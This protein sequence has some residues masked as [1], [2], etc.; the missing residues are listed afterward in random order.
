[1]FEHVQTPIR[2]A[3]FTVLFMLAAC[4]T[5]AAPGLTTGPATKPA[6]A[7][8]LSP[9]QQ[10]I[11]FSLGEPTPQA[12]GPDLRLWAT[13]YHTPIIKPAPETISAAFPLLGRDG[14]PISPPLQHHD[15]CEAAL[16]GSVSIKQ[17]STSTAYVFV[18]A[19]GPEQVNC[20]A[21][22]GNLSDGVKNATRRARF[23]AVNHP[24]G[25]GVRNL[26]LMPF[27]T[28]AVDPDVI[29]LES[30]IFVPE[31]RGRTFRYDG[32]NFV[33][34]GYLFAGDRGGAIQ[35]RH[36]D[37]FMVDDGFAPLEDLFASTDTR[38][39]E[40]HVVDARDPMAE[41]VKASQSASCEPIAR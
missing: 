32:Q 4:A 15:W 10:A 29:P 6:T 12:L 36:V 34:D 28:I 38:T 21:F 7:P 19:N 20:D 18:D 14:S 26:P 3:S 37:V 30:V 16:Q 2:R 9:F 22:L 13:H 33:H 27:R 24:L 25:C 40:A 17:G 8:T 11:G 31:L 5:A 1:M 23:M 35:G 39:F 41:A